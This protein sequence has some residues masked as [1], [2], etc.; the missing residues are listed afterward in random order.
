VRT[1]RQPIPDL[2]QSTDVRDAWQ[3]CARLALRQKGIVTRAQLIALGVPPDWIKR[4]CKRGALHRLYPGVYAVGHLALS[5][6][7]RLQA[8]L[9]ACGPDAVLSHA[10]AAFL[11]GLSDHLP[12][13]ID[14]TVKHGQ[15]RPKQGICL[16]HVSSLGEGDLRRREGLPLTSPARTIIDRAAYVTMDELERLVSEAR[17]RELLRPGELEAAL[18]RAG[19]RHGVGRIRAF[20]D[21][22]EE[23]D[24]TRSKGERRLRRLLR[25]ARLSQP[26]ANARIGRWPVDFLWPDEKLVVE[27]DGFRFHGHRRAFERDRRKDVELVNAGYQVLRFTWRQ[28]KE[29]PLAVLAAIARALGR[30]SRT[31]A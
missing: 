31:A 16:H 13:M 2:A 24:F 5:P 7:A 18:G 6:L 15:R 25:Q 9:L 23:P 3:V 27:F 30:L 29:E 1:K 12:A 17:A 21:S 11:W 22:E 20:L 19:R 26:R 8:A 10:A 14:I 4:W 28:L